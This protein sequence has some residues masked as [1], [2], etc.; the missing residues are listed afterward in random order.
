[1][2]LW[3]PLNPYPGTGLHT[4]FLIPE[5]GMEAA[6]V[7]SKFYGSRALIGMFTTR[8]WNGVLWWV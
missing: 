1:M 5:A 2:H 4:V 7:P 3:L 8:S 6:R